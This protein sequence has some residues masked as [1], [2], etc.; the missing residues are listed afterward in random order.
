MRD[1][2]LDKRAIYKVLSPCQTDHNKGVG[3][4]VKP[5]FEILEGGLQ[6]RPS[7]SVDFFF[8]VRLGHCFGE[9]QI[10]SACREIEG[11]M[12]RTIGGLRGSTILP[13]RNPLACR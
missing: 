2:I 8:V 4:L 9:T 7:K 12:L 1:Q 10:T 5:D 6:K 3:V 13:N 11:R